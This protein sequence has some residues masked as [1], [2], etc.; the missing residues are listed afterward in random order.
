M[1]NLFSCFQEDPQ[2]MPG[3]GLAR[4]DNYRST[5]MNAEYANM[6]RNL[7]GAQE[8]AYATE[9]EYGGK[10]NELARRRLQDTVTGTQGAA[11]VGQLYS[12]ALR[13]ADP[14]NAMLM[15][16]LTATA[17]NDLALGANV[18]PALLRIAQQ[19]VRGRTLNTLGSKGKAGDYSEALGVSAFA[20]DLRTQRRG[21]AQQVSAANDSRYAGAAP[22]ALGISGISTGSIINPATTGTL[23][24]S[25]YTENQSNNRTQ[26]QLETEVGMKQADIW[27]GWFSMAAGAI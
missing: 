25:A 11:G 2:D 23:M 1:G 6:I 12:A 19:S 10:Y 17:N 21:F 24:N 7:A 9:A 15:D 5:T 14:S 3:Q 26:S 8:Q 16:R 20:N 4:T 27:N 22:A 13:S 18:D